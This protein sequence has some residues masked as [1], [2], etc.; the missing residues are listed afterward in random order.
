MAQRRTL[1]EVSINRQMRGV[2]RAALRGWW[3]SQVSVG[4]YWA[5][6]PVT[7]AVLLSVLAWRM[8]A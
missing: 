5:I 4:G 7:A 3:D 2:R 6:I 1:A 8:L